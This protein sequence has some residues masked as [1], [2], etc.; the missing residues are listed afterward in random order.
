M[1]RTAT[2]LFPQVIDGSELWGQGILAGV[3][4]SLLLSVL[5]FALLRRSSRVHLVLAEILTSGSLGFAIMCTHFAHHYNLNY[6]RSPPYLIE[7]AVMDKE[8][9]CGRKAPC[10]HWVTV[11]NWTERGQR[12]VD[13]GAKVFKSVQIGDPVVF[14][15]R[16]GAL[17]YRW[18]EEAEISQWP[19]S[20]SPTE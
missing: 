20:E 10:R 13:V 15:Q 12:R 3:G 8:K 9:Q 17:G 11:S 7:R 14:T 2:G 4:L 1:A 18:L 6:D 16:R 5:A 19:I